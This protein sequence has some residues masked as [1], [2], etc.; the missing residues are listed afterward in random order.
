MNINNKVFPIPTDKSIEEYYKRCCIF[1][2]HHFGKIDGLK[3]YKK[4]MNCIHNAINENKM[5]IALHNIQQKCI[6]KGLIISALTNLDGNCMFES[7][8][9]AGVCGVISIAGLRNHI[10]KIMKKN[11]DTPNY[12]P[13]NS[14]T[15]NQI[16]NLLNIEDTQE[17]NVKYISHKK[18]IVEYNYD[19]M[20]E[21]LSTLSSW[22]RLPTQLV[23]MVIALIYKL[24]IVIINDGSD[25]FTD[26][27]IID[28]WDI[29]TNNDIKTI[30]MGH[31]LKSHYILLDKNENIKNPV[32]IK[33][34]K[35]AKNL[36]KF[37]NNIETRVL[38]NF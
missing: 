20:C 38:K 10:A 29:S 27:T 7:I 12:F 11:K 1:L 37:K 32:S 6:N 31:V 28:I 16:F 24:R 2:V 19:V 18:N 13:N 4:F 25:N 35:A 34:T 23:L 3:L 26:E 22:T 5:N 17:I 33:Y 36:K 9:K 15:L 21:D 30:Y 8:I 14:N